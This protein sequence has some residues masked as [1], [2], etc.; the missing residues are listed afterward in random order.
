[1]MVFHSV[2]IRVKHPSKRSRKVIGNTLTFAVT[3]IFSEFLIFLFKQQ[4]LFYFF[5]FFIFRFLA[6]QT[7]VWLS[8]LVKVIFNTILFDRN[9]PF[10]CCEALV[11]CRTL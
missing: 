6:L 10:S 4:S 8:D 5:F 9:S 3:N 2:I 1:M 11:K 7:W